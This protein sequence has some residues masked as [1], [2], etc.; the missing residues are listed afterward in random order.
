V[1]TRARRAPGRA[2]IAHQDAF[3]FLPAI[4]SASVDLLLTDPSSMIDVPDVLSFAAHW[5]PLALSRSTQVG[6]G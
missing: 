3:T 1:T 6:G 4:A 2:E 5:V